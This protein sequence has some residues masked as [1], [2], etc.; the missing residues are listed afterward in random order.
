MK[1]LLVLFG[2]LKLGKV[3]TTGGTMLL[4]VFGIFSQPLQHDSDFALRRWA[5]HGGAVL[6][7]RVRFLRVPI[8]VALF[9]Y[10]P[11]PM[12]ILIALLAA[13]Q[14]LKA[15]RFDPRAPE[16]I[17]YYGTTKSLRA[18]DANPNPP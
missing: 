9:F 12:L 1:A 14:L 6:T 18:E 3:L 10:R 8:L 4:S 13:P 17:A 11:S 15:W 2:A 7:P 5:N 16:N